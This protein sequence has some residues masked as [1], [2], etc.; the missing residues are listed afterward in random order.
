MLIFV[1]MCLSQPNSIIILDSTI[2]FL[3]ENMSRTKNFIFFTSLKKI[4]LKSFRR[5]K[6]LTSNNPTILFSRDGGGKVDSYEIKFHIFFPRMS[7]LFPIYFREVTPKNYFHNLKQAPACFS[8]TTLDNELILPPSQIVCYFNK[9]N[10]S[11]IN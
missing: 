7:K 3:Q 5:A 11:Q 8:I 9:I 2:C 4:I 10:L 6:Q 1:Q